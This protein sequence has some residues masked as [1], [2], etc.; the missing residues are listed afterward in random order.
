MSSLSLSQLPLP[1]PQPAGTIL[2]SP[3]LDL[4]ITSP[5]VSNSPNAKTDWLIVFDTDAPKLAKLLADELP[6]ESS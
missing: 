4:A 6:G 2:I 5:L 3:W 1:L